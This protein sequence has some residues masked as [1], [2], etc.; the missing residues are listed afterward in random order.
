MAAPSAVEART[1]VAS[2]Q[3]GRMVERR[4]NEGVNYGEVQT[5]QSVFSGRCEVL[6]PVEIL[7]ITG[8]SW[9]KQGVVDEWRGSAVANAM[10]GEGVFG[11]QIAGCCCHCRP[12]TQRWHIGL[13]ALIDPSPEVGSSGVGYPIYPQCDRG[14]P[15]ATMAYWM[16]D[17]PIIDGVTILPCEGYS[18]F[19]EIHCPEGLRY[20]H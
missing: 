20:S 19:T 6:I 11:R 13:E 1:T 7:L 16:L 18:R 4:V 3:W 14:G 8:E 17:I 9:L 2:T 10:A 12:H 5:L 15:C